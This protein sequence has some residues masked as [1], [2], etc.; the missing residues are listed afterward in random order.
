[1]SDRK[2]VSTFK[3]NSE[4]HL[5]FVIRGLR[6]GSQAVYVGVHMGV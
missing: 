5:S 3:A 6:H 2:D 4:E 1:M